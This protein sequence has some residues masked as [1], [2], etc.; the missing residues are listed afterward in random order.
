MVFIY[1]LI[2]SYLC[3]IG[4]KGTIGEY[5]NITFFIFI[6]THHSL[7]MIFFFYI[8]YYYYRILGFHQESQNFFKFICLKFYCSLFLAYHIYMYTH[9]VELL[10]IFAHRLNSP[11]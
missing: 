8:I 7:E 4:H 9:L 5:H 11:H 10:I 2:W 3:V 1:W 6:F